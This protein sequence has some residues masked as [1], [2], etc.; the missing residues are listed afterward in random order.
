MLAHLKVGLLSRQ[1]LITVL[2]LPHLRPQIRD[3]AQL[4]P[5]R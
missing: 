3:L 4:R 2:Q 1:P 5:I